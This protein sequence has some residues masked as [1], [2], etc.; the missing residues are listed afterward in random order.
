MGEKLKRE[1]SKESNERKEKYKV[2]NNELFLI[3]QTSLDIIYSQVGLEKTEDNTKKI[4]RL[5]VHF[6]GNIENV[7]LEILDSAAHLKYVQKKYDNYNNLDDNA[8]E[9]Y[10]ARKILD[11]KDVI[12]TNYINETKRKQAAYAAEHPEDVIVE[13][14]DVN[15]EVNN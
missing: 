4:C 14:E 2:T 12:F 6:G 10:K 11:E 8:K 9:L 15:T 1:I 7:V 13:D 5:F 3:N